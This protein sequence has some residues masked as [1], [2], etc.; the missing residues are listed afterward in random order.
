M[1]TNLEKVVRERNRITWCFDT[2]LEYT[3]LLGT[4]K[5]DHRHWMEKAYKGML[6]DA[7]VVDECCRRFKRE[8]G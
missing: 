6:H 1:K 5:T 7:G 3:R 4:D 8:F 2:P